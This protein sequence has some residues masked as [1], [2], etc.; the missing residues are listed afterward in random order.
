MSVLRS[1]VHA[2]TSEFIYVKQVLQ[3]TGGLFA[4]PKRLAR[5]VYLGGSDET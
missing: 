5:C 2:C 3:A 4:L 1:Y